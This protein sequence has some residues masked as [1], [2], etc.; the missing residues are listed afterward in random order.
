[1]YDLH[2]WTTLPY[3]MVDESQE[4]TAATDSHNLDELQLFLEA[5]PHRVRWDLLSHNPDAVPILVPGPVVLDYE[6]MK[7]SRRE[8]HEDL[9]KERFHPR[10]IKKF[11]GWGFER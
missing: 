10:N 4:G 1:M 3:W 6:A 11:E 9:M 2:D 5:A 8:L 7:A